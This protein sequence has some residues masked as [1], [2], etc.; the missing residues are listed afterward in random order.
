MFVLPQTPAVAGR[1]PAP[2]SS[3]S[4]RVDISSKHGS[5]HFGRWVV[6]RFGLPA[7]R[8]TIDQLKDPRAQNSELAGSVDAWH[9][10][11][12]DRI[13]ANAYNHGYVQLWSQERQYQ[14]INYPAPSEKHFAGGYGYLRTPS[15]MFSTLYVDRPK[16]A[17]TEREFGVGYVRRRTTVPGSDVEEFVYAP[18]G[19]ESVLLHDV[20]VRNT[21][22]R[23]VKASWF[24]YW[25]VNPQIQANSQ[26]RRGVLSPSFNASTRTLMAQQ[27]P[28]PDDPD[29]FTVYASALHGPLNGYDTDV[30]AFFGSGTRDR[31]AAVVAGKATDSIAAPSTGLT[32][33]A[34]MFAFQAP[35]KL[36]PGESITL[37]YAYGA[38]QQPKIG[39][40]VSRAR[41]TSLQASERSWVEWLPQVSFPTAGAWLS[42]ELQWDAYMVR[43]GATYE[44]KCGH[45]ILSQGGYYQYDNAF[46]GAFRDP[47]QHMMPMIYSHPELAREVL[48]YSA[49]EQ[50]SGN[51]FVPYAMVSNCTRFDLGSSDDLDFWLLWAAAEYAMATRD[52]AFFDEVIPY[53]DGGSASMWEHLRVAFTHQ[54][55]IV[56]RGPHGGYITGATGDWSDFQTQFMQMTESM[57][58]TAQLAYAYPLLA[59]VADVRGDK[60]FASLLRGVG[61]FNRQTLVREWTGKGWFSRGYSGTRQ[62]GAGAINSEPQP[63]AVLA[64]AASRSRQKT[65]VRNIRRFLTGIGAPGGPS[66]IGS[67]QSPARNDPEV[68]EQG[69]VPQ[70]S[71]V[72]VGNVWFALNGAL[73]WGVAGI[74][75]KFAW[76]EFVRNTLAQH[77][78]AFPDHWD[79]VISTDDVCH[80]WYADPPEMCSTG[81]TTRYFTQILHQ[82]AWSLLDAIKLAGIV[83]NRDGYRIEPHVLSE[84]YSLRMPLVGVARGPRVIRGYIRPER[85]GKIVMDVV[86]PRGIK[87]ATAWAN[88]KPIAVVIRKGTVRFVLPAKRRKAADWAVTW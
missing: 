78:S 85:G 76:D 59:Q 68:T 82:P 13:V 88:G 65:L 25:D 71:A 42:R 72:Y 54:E 19:D 63:W 43:S 77:A 32:P 46:Q 44:E 20:T 56:G 28:L 2:L 50:P 41:L 10:I 45:H 6:D 67:A 52:F 8:Y 17:K 74:D 47:L 27:S 79:G 33:N 40:I 36:A 7:Y 84:S 55:N 80:A 9:Q 11:G 26:T 86:L 1:P 62:I 73:V 21:G 35:L 58:V 60:E 66:K 23:N 18:F 69:I 83:P 61:E 53:Y 16:D 29:P 3:D 4:T 5:G 30:N 51:G 15:R 37:R 70:D 24:E 81:L 31:P 75:E 49:R 38:V 87:R 48:R 12:N 39:G 57:L 22:K 14:W 34:S 64:G